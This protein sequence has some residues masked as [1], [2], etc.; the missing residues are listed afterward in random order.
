[1]V[2][3]LPFFESTDF[4]SSAVAAFVKLFK[5]LSMLLGN[6]LAL[7]KY[8]SKPTSLFSWFMLMII[9]HMFL[10]IEYVLPFL[11][12]CSHPHTLSTRHLLINLILLITLS[13]LNLFLISP[14]NI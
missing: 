4:K 12:S 10:V 2:S 8:N 3:A 13:H 1:M 9:L 7:V 5:T 6:N 14:T 11:F